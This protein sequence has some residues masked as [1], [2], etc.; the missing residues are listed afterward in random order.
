MKVQSLLERH[1]VTVFA[2][3]GPIEA[4]IECDIATESAL[5]VD[6][7]SPMSRLFAF[8]L[9]D[10]NFL[11]KAWLASQVLLLNAELFAHNL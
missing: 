11:R 1:Y 2:H 9:A 10:T 3:V 4:N 5:V 8:C 7:F 6:E